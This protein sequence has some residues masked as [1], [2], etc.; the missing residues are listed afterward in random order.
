MDPK[1]EVELLLHFLSIRTDETK[2]GKFGQLSNSD[3]DD[4]IQQSV[5]HG[6]APLLY[7]RLKTLN[8]SAN[9]TASIVQRL[10]EIYLRSAW[11]NTRLYHE[12]SK[13]LSLLQNDGIPVIVLKGAALAETAYQNIAL[14]PMGDVDLLVKKEDLYRTEITLLSLGYAVPK[15]YLRKKLDEKSHHHLPPYVKENRIMV[16]VHWNIF[17]KR[18]WQFLWRLTKRD[19]AILSEFK[20]AV[21]QKRQAEILERWLTS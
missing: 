1:K 20:Q 7:Q 13:V 9:I 11:E 12:L 6:V 18:Y 21:A 14:R 15:R 19:K 5:R 17:I 10:R 2:V 4:I 16:E 3:W 8:P